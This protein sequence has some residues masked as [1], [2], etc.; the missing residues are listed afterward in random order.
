M[1]S[2]IASAKIGAFQ[3][4]FGAIPFWAIFYSSPMGPSNSIAP[5]AAAASPLRGG[6]EH[7][8]MLS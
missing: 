7:A 8:A 4:A 6:M 1:N 5:V 3:Q 2:K